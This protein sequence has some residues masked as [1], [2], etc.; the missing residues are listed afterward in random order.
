MP[1]AA[2]HQWRAAHTDRWKHCAVVQP[3]ELPHADFVWSLVKHPLIMS[4]SDQIHSIKISQSYSHVSNCNKCN[5]IQM[6]FD[7]ECNIKIH[8][9]V[10][11]CQ[12]ETLSRKQVFM[13]FIIVMVVLRKM[14][15]IN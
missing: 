15:F 1:P 14:L 9:T 5:N 6:P 10:S 2:L 13:T 8:V 12:H 4:T 7:V 11:K 3:Q